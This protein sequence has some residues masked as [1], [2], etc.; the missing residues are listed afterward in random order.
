M[1]K[2]ER[3]I[4]DISIRGVFEIE[5]VNDLPESGGLEAVSFHFNDLR[6]RHWA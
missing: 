1:G 3:W 4:W 2:W 5:W 6:R